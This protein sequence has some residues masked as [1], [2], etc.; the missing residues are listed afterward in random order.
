M[1][2]NKS[3]FHENTKKETQAK[4]AYSM[5]LMTLSVMR[6]TSVSCPPSTVSCGAIEWRS[7]SSSISGPR[8]ASIFAL[9]PRTKSYLY[10]YNKLEEGL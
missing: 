3:S 5:E 1:K 8:D 10:I 2:E 7:T 6:L 4:V 9:N